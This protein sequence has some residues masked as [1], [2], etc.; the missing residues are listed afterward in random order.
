MPGHHHRKRKCSMTLCAEHCLI[1]HRIFILA[2]RVFIDEI[3]PLAKYSYYIFSKYKEGPAEKDH[4]QLNH[5]Y[6][7]SPLL[8]IN[9][10]LPFSL[11]CVPRSNK[12]MTLSLQKMEKFFMNVPLCKAWDERKIEL[13]RITR[14]SNIHTPCHHFTPVHQQFLTRLPGLCP[15]IKQTND[16]FPWGNGDVFYEY[17]LCKA[18]DERKAGR[19]RITRNSTIH[20]TN[21]IQS[22]RNMQFKQI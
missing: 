20:K 15:W 11:A 2:S 16:S 14:N 17:P 18:W 19:K 7:L 12:Q 10:F 13:M 4:M 3:L 21:C 6:S 9:N 5:S 1:F 8:Y 22:Q